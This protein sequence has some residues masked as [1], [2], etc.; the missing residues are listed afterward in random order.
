MLYEKLLTAVE[1]TSTFGLE[2]AIAPSDQRSIT[3]EGGTVYLFTG[4]TE[5]QNESAVHARDHKGENDVEKSFSEWMD[6]RA[7]VFTFCNRQNILTHKYS[8]LIN[9]CKNNPRLCLPRHKSAV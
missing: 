6:N 4:Q 1:E 8:A 5:D 2:W 7:T 3:P 9:V